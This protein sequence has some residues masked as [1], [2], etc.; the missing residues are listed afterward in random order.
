MLFAVLSRLAGLPYTLPILMCSD[1][2][3]IV[4][5]VVCPLFEM[6]ESEETLLRSY[7]IGVTR[8]R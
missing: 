1:N 8:A 5:H 4:A 7:L 6:F 3:Q 2:Q